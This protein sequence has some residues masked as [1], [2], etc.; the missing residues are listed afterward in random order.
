MVGAGERRQAARIAQLGFEHLDRNE[1]AP[2][3]H[4]LAAHHDGGVTVDERRNVRARLA[5]HSRR[6]HNN[7]GGCAGKHFLETRRCLHV[8]I[9]LTANE[10]A[11]IFVTFVYA[12]THFLLAR[13]QHHVV[14]TKPQNMRKR[15]AP[16]TS[17]NN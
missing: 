13:P 9:N 11:G 14:A 10:I 6:G 2:L 12:V 16:R 3:F 5:N 4:A 7:H 15:R 1:A 8:G 17:A